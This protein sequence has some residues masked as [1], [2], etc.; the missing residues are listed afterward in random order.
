MFG[1]WRIKRPNHSMVVSYLAL[2]VAL[3]TG[4]AYAANTIGSSDI[5][6]ESILSQDVKNGS[7]VGLD[8]APSAIGSGRVLNN[9]LTTAD[10]AGADVN[11]GQIS[12]SAGAV[13]NGRCRQVSVS[14]RGSKAGEAVVFSSQ[15][16]LQDG[17]LL[18]GQRVATDG[19]VTLDVCNFS[20]TVQAAITSLPVRVITF[21]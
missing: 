15:G 13:A 3:S 7:L 12:I 8:L 11:G 14:I 6:D 5:I 17:I 20:G 18:Y 16:P 19:T 21:G 1:T 10:V 4:T 2:F 9:S